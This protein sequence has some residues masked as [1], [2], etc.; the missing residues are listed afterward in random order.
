MLLTCSQMRALEESAFADGVTAEAL[1]EEA[2]LRIAQAVRQFFPTPGRCVVFLGKGHNAGD[3]LVAARHLHAAGWGIQ[4]MP[5]FPH[6]QWAELTRIQGDRL[7]KAAAEG[8]S[9]E[10][11]LVA[12][13]CLLGIGAGGA[14]RDPIL[15]ACRKINQLRSEQGAHVFAI[16]LPTGVNGDTGVAD[17]G[18]VVADTTLTIG[19]AKT[20]LVADLAVNHVGRLA[21]LPLHELTLRSA[22]LDVPGVATVATGSALR[23]L[24]PPRAF[25]THKGQ[26]GR[27]GVIA[28]SMGYTGAACLCAEGAVRGGAG[29]VTLYVTED[30]YPIV[31]ARVAPEVM[32]RPVKTHAEVLYEKLDSVAIGPGLGKAH[33][34]TIL[35]I[36]EELRQPAVLDADALNL[37]AT[38]ISVL[39]R[40]AGPRLLTPHPGEMARLD[41]ESAALPR[42]QV[43]ERFTERWPHVLLLKG[44]RTIVGQRGEPLSCNTTGNPGMATGGIGDVLT[45]LLAALA[46]QGRSLFDAARLGAWLSGRAA[47]I[48]IFSGA[49]SI[50]TFRP[51]ALLE[52]LAEAFNDLR[53]E[54]Y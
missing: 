30:I 35:Q 24:L 32:V 44:A 3:G 8:G 51:S 49:D 16:D 15:R 31:A 11:P 17:P 23:S 5:A 46:A 6:E 20:G 14:L 42:A 43:V 34:Q 53:R 19:F 10:W 41:P 25:D 39:D 37:L 4:L 18:A 7:Q 21:V 28:G 33:A 27:V 26:C 22:R 13:D 48:R 45:G 29:L 2:G 38:D 47:E 9:P 52:S 1:M 36:I 54:G 40:T 50:E 12:L